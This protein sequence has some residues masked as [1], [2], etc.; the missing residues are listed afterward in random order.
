MVKLSAST[1]AKFAKHTDVIKAS[2][3]A[4]TVDVAALSKS[5]D[6][7]AAQL[8]SLTTEMK[9]ATRAETADGAIAGSFKGLSKSDAP[10]LK[11]KTEDLKNEKLESPAD[12]KS[13]SK[14]LLDNVGTAN[15][16][17]TAGLGSALLY[18][19]I[20]KKVSEDTPRT[21]TKVEM[22]GTDY[23]ITY[24]PAINILTTD[25]IEISGSSV[26]PD[27]NG[28][29]SVIDAPDDDV[30]II[31]GAGNITTPCT[32]T[33]CGTIKVKSSV[34]GQMAD[35]VGNLIP[36]LLPDTNVFMKYWWVFLIIALVVCSSSAAAFMMSGK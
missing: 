5:V 10:E 22:S 12:I 4:S 14:K 27:I 15:L 3:K 26:V 35:A 18:F 29:R 20:R 33:S 7:I 25:E 6:D 34:Y 28:K 23:K 30:I 32:S 17:V 19:Y 16:L 1:L 24:T 11:T 2:K 31:R 13:V 9:G 21:I 36:D 8:S